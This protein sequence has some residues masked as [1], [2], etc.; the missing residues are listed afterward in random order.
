MTGRGDGGHKS[1]KSDGV[2]R[3]VRGGVTC[4]TATESANE[5]QSASGKKKAGICNICKGFTNKTR[6][7]KDKEVRNIKEK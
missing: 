7:T 6:S 1:D 4:V 3:G 2:D 5:E